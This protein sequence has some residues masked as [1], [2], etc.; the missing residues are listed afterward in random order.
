MNTK[1]IDAIIEMN[2]EIYCQPCVD[3]PINIA[4]QNLNPFQVI[5]KTCKYF[6]LEIANVISKKRDQHLVFARMFIS[7]MLYR[8]TYL[9]LS[10]ANIGVI[11]GGRD[12]TTIM[13]SLR[14]LKN[15]VETDENF[16]EKLINIHMYVYSTTKYL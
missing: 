15:L 1:T 10:L 8:D 3:H 13:A 12:H 11:L 9:N 7:H 5:E 6:Q 4:T 14:S 2:K 16:K